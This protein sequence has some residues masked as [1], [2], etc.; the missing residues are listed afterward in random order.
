ME[1][2]PKSLRGMV[3]GT[4]PLSPH[5][6]AHYTEKILQ[7]LAYLHENHIVHR[8]IKAANILLKEDGSVKV[9][10][11]GT[12]MLS[13]ID[14]GNSSSS[15]AGGGPLSSPA[16]ANNA[17]PLSG[18]SGKS[19]PLQG[20]ALFLAPEVVN[21]SLPTE[22]SDIW[23]LGC[24]V[25]ELAT[26]QYPWSELT[27]AMIE[28]PNDHAIA[29]FISQAQSPPSLNPT[30]CPAATLANEELRDFLSQCLSMDPCLRPTAKQLLH[31][32]F[33]LERHHGCNEEEDDDAMALT[34]GEVHVFTG[35]EL[36]SEVS[37]LNDPMSMA[38]DG[39]SFAQS[40]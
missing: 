2:C 37:A 14:E 10:D 4:G 5:L 6:I 13:E 7:G 24:L 30:Y 1:Y 12:A 23:S 15:G 19:V 27:D 31:H 40:F 36:V 26:G 16:T 34:G 3:D 32:R 38:P 29:F 22:A 33:L 18:R 8:D 21:E 11:F 9:S 28:P 35:G 25:I 39:A 17:T 20:T